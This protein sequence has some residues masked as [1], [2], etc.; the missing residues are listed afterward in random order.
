MIREDDEP[1]S[2]HGAEHGGA[3]DLERAK[4]KTL[5][6]S[7]THA[8]PA[9]AQIHL[10][11]E[12][13]SYPDFPEVG[14]SPGEMTPGDEGLLSAAGRLSMS[15]SFSTFSLHSST[16]S[17]GPQAIKEAASTSSADRKPNLLA[18]VLDRHGHPER[19]SA[20]SELQSRPTRENLSGSNAEHHSTLDPK[21]LRPLTST[22][23]KT[24]IAAI[25]HASEVG[26]AAR[27]EQQTTESFIGSD[28]DPSTAGNHPPTKDGEADDDGVKRS[29]PL[30]QP[31]DGF[32][33]PSKPQSIPPPQSM[34]STSSTASRHH[35]VQSSW[36]NASS[37]TQSR[38]NIHLPPTPGNDDDDSAASPL[39]GGGDTGIDKHEAGADSKGHIEG[40]SLAG[41]G[42]VIVDKEGGFGWE[43]GD[44]KCGAP[45]KVEWLKTEPL[46]FPRIKNLRNP[47]NND[48]EVV[49]SCIRLFA[50]ALVG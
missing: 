40:T 42:G 43:R 7:G 19:A 27:L 3:S 49:S 9:P 24:A 38:P 14:N 25:A 44:V 45:F 46:R 36:S 50:L 12:P 35:S 16:S 8:A 13:C 17:A 41:G 31:D 2:I 11:G 33:T 47:W 34:L 26:D 15:P 28:G 18:K 30:I 32:A 21:A 37:I 22:E 1:I 6:N 10:N 4:A 23:Q 29:D 39:T 48:R 20:P 5:P